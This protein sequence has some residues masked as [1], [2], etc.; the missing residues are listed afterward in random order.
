MREAFFCCYAFHDANNK[1]QHTNMLPLLV[2]P[3]HAYCFREAAA[4]RRAITLDA[5]YAVE[6]RDIPRS[7]SDYAL[8]PIYLRRFAHTPPPLFMFTEISFSYFAMP[9]IFIACRH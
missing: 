3:P 7:L 1:Q 5:D 2:T 8:L 4:A 9:F 6:M